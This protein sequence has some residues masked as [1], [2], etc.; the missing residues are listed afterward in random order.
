MGLLALFA[1]GIAGGGGPAQAHPAAASDAGAGGQGAGGR[2]LPAPFQPLVVIPGS[3]LRIDVLPGGNYGVWRNN[4]QQFFAGY[5]ETVV[6]WVDGA[7]YGAARCGPP[8][9]NTST[10]LTGTGT[11]ADPWLVTS[12]FNVG[13]TGLKLSQQVRYVDGQEYLR[14]DWSICNTG[15]QNFTN[16]HLFHAAD[17]FTD[18]NDN[19]YGYYDAATGAIGGYNVSHTLYQIFIPITPARHYEED[20]YSII[21]TDTCN[22]NGTGY[23][24]SYVPN[25]LIDNGAGLEWS[26][27]A[28]PNSCT[29]I[30]D[31]LSFA[32][33]PVL[34]TA[35][36]PPTNTP[37]PTSTPAP[38]T[39]TRPPTGTSEPATRTPTPLPPKNTVTPQPPTATPSPPPTTCATQTPTRVPTPAFTP[40]PGCSAIP[41][42]QDLRAVITDHAGATE[43]LFTN[44]SA[45]CSYP[46]G[47]AV[48]QKL[49][50]NINHQQLY[51]YRLAVIPPHSTLV[52]EVNNPPCAYQGDAFWGALIESFAN[53]ERYGERRLDDT[54]GNGANY[55]PPGCAPAKPTATPLLPYD[56]R[57]TDH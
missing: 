28:P 14:T 25:T 53:G 45:T 13:T 47:L 52:L 9:T 31:F 48:Y 37:L 42:R 44:H 29:N 30:A 36:N 33:V 35:T 57:P 22:I 55:C 16:V 12:L 17:L 18:G 24:N 20:V 11:Q 15:D 3:P 32:D 8:F 26:F 40:A 41:R 2:G 1:A 10:T 49:D 39:S 27:A 38:P 5:A 46:I 54:D 7:L 50:G 19:G 51:D 34:P 21:W 56:L 43:A 6:L 4:V 23:R